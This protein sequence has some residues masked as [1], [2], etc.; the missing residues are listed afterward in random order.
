MRPEPVTLAFELRPQL[1]VIVNFPVENQDGI[2]I[3]ADHRLIAAR[4]IDNLQPHRPQRNMRRFPHT[5]LIRPAMRQRMCERFDPPPIRDAVRVRE[6]GY[7][8]QGSVS[9]SRLK[10]LWKNR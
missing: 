5:L 1:D 8:A 3:V 2:A 6:P 7:P 9:T 4:Q 10:L